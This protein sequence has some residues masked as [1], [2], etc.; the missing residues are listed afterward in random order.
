MNRS[1]LRKAL[2]VIAILLFSTFAWVQY[3]D[4]DPEIYDR[5]SVIDAATWLIFYAFMATLFAV[6][7]FR[8]V[9]KWL[10]M[11]AIVSCLVQLG[12]T[13]PGMWENL[14]GDAPF[15]LT[16]ASMSSQDPRV[17]LSREFLGALIA[18]LAVGALGVCG[19]AKAEKSAG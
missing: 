1:L 3:N 4:I 16:Q 6:A 8:T 9:P 2:Y 14:T 5:P 13:A 19:R 7:L 12:R 17:E 15:T 11:V 18:L 10:L